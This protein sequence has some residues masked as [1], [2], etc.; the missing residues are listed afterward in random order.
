MKN[1][2]D[3]A[4]KELSQDA[5][6]MWLFD[7][8][9]DKDL[10][11]VVENLIRKFCNKEF[12]EIRN[13][14][15]QPQWKKIDVSIHFEADGVKQ[16]IFIED[17]TTSSEHDNQL[18]RYNKEI[19]K[20]NVYKIFYKTTLLTPQEE[21]RVKSAGWE[22]FDIKKIY[23]IFEEFRGNKNVIL[24]QY[25]ERVENMK[26]LADVVEMPEDIGKKDDYYCKKNK[27]TKWYNYFVK[28]TKEYLKDNKEKSEDLTFDVEMNTGR[29]YASILIRN[30][31]NCLDKVEGKYVRK[32]PT[33]EICS[34]NRKVNILCR[35]TVSI[36]RRYDA[37]TAVLNKFGESD[38][39]KITTAEKTV[40][41]MG[42]GAFDKSDL[43][44]KI[45]SW[46]KAYRVVLEEWK[47]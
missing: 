19:D 40:C 17:K 21:K 39:W 6:L 16:H 37:Q 15:V 18:I 33:L 31:K 4:T 26:R 38:G 41:T 45:D 30:A 27:V 14:K 2:F 47:K 3:Y 34:K 9:E 12:K 23:D 7:S 13:I 44:N 46:L 29:E 24:K 43:L 1:L 36:D 28:I 42:E 5:F 22:D 32:Y 11:P 10:Q 35:D 20:Q 25:I 8:W